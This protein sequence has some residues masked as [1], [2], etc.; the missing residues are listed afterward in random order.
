MTKIIGI[1]GSDGS[2]KTSVGRGL[3]EDQDMSVEYRYFTKDNPL[4]RLRNYA[5][6]LSPQKRFF[7]YLT[8][9]LINY[10]LL[11]GELSDD[12]D[13]YIL[14]DR[15]PLSTV[16]YH[17]AMQV[18]VGAYRLF[19]NRLMSQYE[20][21]FFLSARPKV[22]ENRI[23][24]RANGGEIHK[25][26]QFAIQQQELINNAFLKWLPTNSTIIDTSEIPIETVVKIVKSKI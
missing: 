10:S 6:R 20:K 21:I 7:Y 3:T 26:D 1:E 5:D 13:K 17:E 14:M 22:I 4:S 23:L 25:A 19:H 8:V 15:T 11:Q 12:S 16:A 2:G 18:N 24:E 9:N